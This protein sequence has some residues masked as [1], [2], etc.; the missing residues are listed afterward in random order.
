MAATRSEPASRPAFQVCDRYLGGVSSTPGDPNAVDQMVYSCAG[1]VCKLEVPCGGQVLQLVPRQ[2]GCAEGRVLPGDMARQGVLLPTSAVGQH[3]VGEDQEG[4]GQESYSGAAPVANEHLVV[5]SAGDVG[6]GAL[7]LGVLQADPVI[8]TERQAAI[9]ASSVGLSGVRG[10]VA[11]TG[12]AEDLLTMDIRSGTRNVY[13]ARFNHFRTYCDSI[14]VDPQHCSENV[15]VNFLTMLKTKFGYKYQTIA[16]YRSAIS[17]YHDGIHGVPIGQA[18]HVKRVTKAVFNVSPP[19]AKY[20]NI[21]PVDKLL[22]F[23]GTLYPHEDL[24]VSQLGMKCLSLISL[25]S[26]SRSSTVA[27]LGPD[28]QVLGDEFVF[29]ICG[30]EKTSR[31]GHLRRELRCPLD[32]SNPA[33]DVHLCCEDYLSRTEE[34]RV[35]YAAGEGQRPNRLF[36]SSN[37]V[38][39]FSVF[40][41][42]DI[43]LYLS[44]LSTSE[45]L[46]FGEMDAVCHGVCWN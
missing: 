34:R 10:E 17:K 38:C 28:V 37:K 4:Q 41:M 18:K 42:H 9:S 35:Y 27:L 13:T 39:F 30:L 36:I 24:T 25:T 3:G 16:G 21:W 15:V 2:H 12:E 31:Q 11:L 1:S 33:L 23:L 19:I 7:E 20:A 5:S 8:P 29:S 32:S 22:V 26:V 14:G 46:Y 40:F 43:I 6:G 45:E 44:A